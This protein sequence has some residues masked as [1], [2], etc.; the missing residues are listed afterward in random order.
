MDQRTTPTASTQPLSVEAVEAA[1]WV[2]VSRPREAAQTQPPV[3]PRRVVTQ[4]VGGLAVVLLAVGLLGSWAAQ[5]LAEREA[6][7]DAATI[8]DVLAE[9]VIT[10]SLTDALAEG[11]AAAVTAMDAV[12]RERVL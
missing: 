7:T 12:A 1:P 2:T 9:A 8:A 5:R 4:V 11:D 6:V 3:S 10:P